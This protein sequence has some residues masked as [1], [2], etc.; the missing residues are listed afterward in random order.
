[1]ILKD[2]DLRRLYR[3]YV[4]KRAD[5]DRKRCPSIEDLCGFFES[6]T[7]TSKKLKI[8]D[9]VTNCAACAEEFEF[10]R[11]LQQYQ[12]QITQGAREIRA[13]ESPFAPSTSARNGIVSFGQ[14]A[15][16]AVGVL[17]VVA[18]LVITIQEWSRSGDVRAA[19]SSMLLVQPNQRNPGSRPLVFKW[20]EY[21]GAE[22]YVLEL[23]D[24]AL[25][26]VWKSP[27]TSTP[28][29]TLPEDVR[30]RLPA[31]KPYFWMVT[32]YRGGDKLAE[33]ELLRFMLTAKDP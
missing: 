10:L 33:S 5:A 12:D 23:F 18:S 2:E 15:S 20:R 19:P 13:E 29:L 30:E 24:E 9:H 31:N 17:F 14:Y 4:S 7:R 8:V 3:S 28:Y 27:G 21:K 1:M 11:E 32:A 25:L 16:V 22:V 6:R 26:P